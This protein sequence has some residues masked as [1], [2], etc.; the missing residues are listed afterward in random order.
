M[1]KAGNLSK[2]DLYCCDPFCHSDHSMPGPTE[3]VAGCAGGDVGCGRDAGHLV[4][5]ISGGMSV[6]AA[7]CS[8]D[9]VTFLHYE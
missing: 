7:S 5:L 8:L 9:S 4:Y 1:V 2:G 6:N 3:Q